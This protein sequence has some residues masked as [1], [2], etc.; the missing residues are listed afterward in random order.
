MCCLIGYLKRIDYFH[1]KGCRLSDHGLNYVPFEEASQEEINSIFERRRDGTSL[2]GKESQQFQTAIL[3]FL[4][5][6]Y[7]INII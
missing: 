6:A 1:E 2:N 4:S 5:K 7:H 3:V